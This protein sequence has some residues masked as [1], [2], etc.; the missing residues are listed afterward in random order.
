MK[1]AA[2]YQLREHGAESFVET[3]RD[4]RD[5]LAE[6]YFPW[7][8]DASGRASLG[9][10]RGMT[11]W[12]AQRRLE[13]DLHALRDMGLKLDLLFNANCYGAGAV[14]EALENHVG[15]VLVYL[16]DIVGGA[17]I[18]TTTSPLVAHV[19]RTH[20]PSVE[21]RASINMRIGTIAAMSYMSDLFDSFYL[22]RDRQ[23]DIAYVREVKAWCDENG[24]GLCLLANSG[25]LRD[26]PSQSFHDNLVAHDAEI[27]ERKN[28][29]DW[30]PHLCWRLYRDRAR[31]PAILQA[32]WIRPEDAHHYEELC[33]VMKLAMRMHDKPRLVLEAYCSGR[34]RGNLLDL[35]EPGFGPAFAP[36]VLLND[37]LP[38]DWF[39]RTSTCDG[40]CRL[41]DYCRKALA[42]ALVRY[43]E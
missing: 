10:Q 30:V 2:G 15:S 3:I 36:H 23:R 40:R 21:I 18:V 1:F 38:D 34:Y 25:C 32:T 42:Q 14:G 19:V 35:L 8:G 7:V 12:T 20:F 6:V 4:Y 11:N 28:I 43:D 33:R 26:C 27:D 31:W 39:A 9:K 41:C 16:E 5:H 22:Q 13:E 37:R 17:D 24:K 29:P